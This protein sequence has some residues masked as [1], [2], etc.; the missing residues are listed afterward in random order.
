LLEP[1]SQAVLLV[2]QALGLLH[3]HK[4]THLVKPLMCKPNLLKKHWPYSVKCM[5]SKRLCKNRIV[6]LV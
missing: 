2:R 4:L 3:L 1:Q 6:L 5:T